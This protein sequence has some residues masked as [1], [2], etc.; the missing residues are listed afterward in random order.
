[1]V[2]WL[3]GEWKVPGH[4]VEAEHFMCSPKNTNSMISIAKYQCQEKMSAIGHVHVDHI[5]LYHMSII[6]SPQ[7]TTL[8]TASG[9][10][11]RGNRSGDVENPQFFLQGKLFTNPGFFHIYVRWTSLNRRVYAAN[12]RDTPKIR[13]MVAHYGIPEKLRFGMCVTAQVILNVSLFKTPNL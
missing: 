2:E 13:S 11:S 5:V 12:I 3:E 1:M 6:F 8:R 9:N 4:R 10:S 7:K